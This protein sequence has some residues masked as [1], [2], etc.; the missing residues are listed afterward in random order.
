MAGPA[1]TDSTN[2]TLTDQ[3]HYTTAPVRLMGTRLQAEPSSLLTTVTSR[4]RNARALTTL[5]NDPLAEQQWSFMSP[6][7]YTGAADVFNAQIN[8]SS[9]AEVVVAVIDSGVMLTHEDLYTLPGYDFVSTATT[10]NDGDGRDSDPTDPGDWVS[11]EELLTG[12]LGPGCTASDSTWHGTAIAGLIGAA[13]ANN[14]GIAGGAAKVALLPV[15]I[16]GKCGGY[17][18]DMVDGIRWAA[19]LSVSGV[20]ENPHPARIINLSVGFAGRCEADLQRAINDA[21]SAGSIVIAAATNS[22]A[23]LDSSP[24]SPAICDNVLSIAANT[25]EGNLT[26]YSAHG[27]MIFLMAP[28]GTRD[29]GIIT[30]ENRSNS[31]P[32]LASG[33]GYHYG[34]S[35]ASA[36]VSAAV[37]TLLSI[38]PT[39]DNRSIRNTLIN[40]STSITGNSLCDTGGCGHG[41][42]NVDRAVRMLLDGD[43]TTQLDD[44]PANAPATPDADKDNVGTIDPSALVLLLLP[45]AVPRRYKRRNG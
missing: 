31:A 13:S 19:G 22:A 2:A 17:I 42:L 30:T 44:T 24:Y 41:R 20:P 34:T 21:T 5:P 28:G 35:L 15:R 36:H 10:G 7:V 11:D 45:F 9:L 12:N 4:L 43:Q 26:D 16:T 38:D 37:A 32:D 1:Y 23:D 33:Y 18:H 14:L 40:A 25:R 29:D 39:L 8:N 6:T 27:S 3:R